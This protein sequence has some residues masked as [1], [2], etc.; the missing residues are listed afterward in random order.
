MVIYSEISLQNVPA[1]DATALKTL[2]RG[3]MY[4]Q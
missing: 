3:D 1:A 2:I 4:V